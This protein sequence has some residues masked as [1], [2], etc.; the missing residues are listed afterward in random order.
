[1]ENFTSAGFRR[2]REIMDL[3]KHAEKGK[4]QHGNII[5]N[6]KDGTARSGASSDVARPYNELV[7]A[8]K[9]FKGWKDSVAMAFHPNP[10]D[11]MIKTDKGWVRV[12][13]GESGY[14]LNSGSFV[15]F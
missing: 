4:K 9:D 6:R 11:E 12:M 14:Q 10:Q 13:V 2:Q 7:Q 1:M 8:V 5:A 3:F 15:K